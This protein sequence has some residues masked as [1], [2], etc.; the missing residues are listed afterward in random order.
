ML[1][2]EAA[3]CRII[4]LQKCREK[5]RRC[6][7]I[8]RKGTQVRERLVHLLRRLDVLTSQ[9][10]RESAVEP[11]GSSCCHARQEIFV[12]QERQAV[13]RQ[14][15]PR[16]LRREGD[17]RQCLTEQSLEREMPAARLFQIGMLLEEGLPER[18]L[19]FMLQFHSPSLMLSGH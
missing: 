2:S 5:R 14:L 3:D 8:G 17:R 11:P 1:G 19:F 6:L 7:L 15:L 9:Q 12:L 10:E 13:F 4:L 18:L 16:F